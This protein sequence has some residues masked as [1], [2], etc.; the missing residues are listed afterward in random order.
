MD[1][2]SGLC[3]LAFGLASWDDSGSIRLASSDPLEPPRI[4]HGYQRIIDCGGYDSAWRTFHEL[5]GTDAFRSRDAGSA[6]GGLGLREILLERAA[7]AFHPAGGCSIGAV[8]DEELRVAGVEGLR[9]ADASVF[10]AHV[11]NNPNLTCLMVGEVAAAR[12]A[13]TSARPAVARAG[14]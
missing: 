8:V 14:A 7:T 2:E 11:S 1:E 5:L 9:I 3:A 10:P 4:E 12:I 6:E 13:G